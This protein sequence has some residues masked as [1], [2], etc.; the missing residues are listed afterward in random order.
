[1]LFN[2]LAPKGYTWEYNTELMW[3]E[4]GFWRG[5]GTVWVPL[6]YIIEEALSTAYNPSI[7]IATAIEREGIHGH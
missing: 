3:W 7:L 4:L 5:Y 6:Q 2:Y 1:M